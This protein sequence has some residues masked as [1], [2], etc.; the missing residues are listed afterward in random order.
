MTNFCI[1]FL[2]EVFFEICLCIMINASFVDFDSKSQ[3]IA[4]GICIFLALVTFIALIAITVLFWKKGGP[5][6][7]DAFEQRSLWSS[8]W[9][10]RPLRASTMHRMI[11]SK[12]D[13]KLFKQNKIAPSS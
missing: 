1:R 8:F 9:G 7:R 3:L 10:T 12:E 2:Y 11:M 4:W 13:K 5:S 6:V